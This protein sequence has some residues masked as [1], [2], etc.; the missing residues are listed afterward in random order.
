MSEFKILWQA[1][2]PQ[3]KPNL[4][5]IKDL[6]N[7]VYLEI[8]DGEPFGFD[9]ETNSLDTHADLFWIRSVAFTNDKLSFSVEIRDFEGQQIDAELEVK[10]F[11]WLGTQ[12]GNMVSHNSSYECACLYRAIGIFVKP[13]ADTYVLFKY[14]SNEGFLGQ[15]WGLDYLCT[16]VLSWDRYSEVLDNHLKERGLSKG[17]MCHADWE[18]LGWYNQL[19]T[20]ATWEAY[21]RFKEV[22]EQ[23]QDTW[24]KYFWQIHNEDVMNL[25]ELQMEALYNGLKV[26][27]TRLKVYSDTLDVEIDA[28]L[29]NFFADTRVSA[30]M[31][32]WDIKVLEAYQEAK[33][34]ERFIASGAYHGQYLNSLNRWEG[35]REDFIRE[36][37]FNIGSTHHLK[38]L[39]S[40]IFDVQIRGEIVTVRDKEKK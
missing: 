13:L 5:S 28:A 17:E 10:L 11:Q 31:K 6:Y 3:P 19:D 22:V 29:D 16:E 32:L 40:T 12:Q 35:R 15:N 25:L 37:A 4:I 23:Y 7:D 9:F 21:K 20:V 33:P 2:A 14:L 8:L 26:D 38:W 24:G 36:N 39:T 27:K 1:K 18:V 30:A 34:K